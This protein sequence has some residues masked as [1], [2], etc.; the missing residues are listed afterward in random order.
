LQQAVDG[1][2]EPGHDRRFNTTENRYIF[3]CSTENPHR[4]SASIQLIQCENSIILDKDAQAG[5]K[6]QLAHAYRLGVAEGRE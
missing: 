5:S 3:S 1:R 6:S 2:D 4:L